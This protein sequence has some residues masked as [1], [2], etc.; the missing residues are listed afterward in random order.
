MVEEMQM[1]AEQEKQ[2]PTL[3]E[4]FRKLDE[5]LAALENRETTLEE[6]FRIYEQ[7]MELIKQ[8]GAQIDRVEKKIQLINEEGELREF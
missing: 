6:S 1:G 3:E 2:E 4:S 8:C 5:I 7:G